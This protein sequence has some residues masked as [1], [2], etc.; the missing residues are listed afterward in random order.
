MVSQVVWGRDDSPRDNCAS[1]DGTQAAG[2]KDTS[3]P[4]VF[5]EKQPDEVTPRAFVHS[6][7]SWRS[8]ESWCTARGGGIDM[9]VG[10]QRTSEE[11]LTY[12]TKVVP[13]PPAGGV[14]Q[15]VRRLPSG[16]P[17]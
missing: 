8:L 3:A 2:K 14:A 6:T 1:P 7:G 13:G 12:G 10:S 4:E 11:P 5:C 16:S 9:Q 15:S 17:G